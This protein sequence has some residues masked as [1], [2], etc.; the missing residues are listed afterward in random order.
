MAEAVEQVLEKI[1]DGEAE[2]DRIGTGGTKSYS[3]EEW[4]NVTSFEK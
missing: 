3:D 1:K 2:Y 4:K